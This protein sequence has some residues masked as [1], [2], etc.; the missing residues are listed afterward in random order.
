M[1]TH[2][3]P[4]GDVHLRDEGVEREEGLVALDPVAATRQ[5]LRKS[6]ARSWLTRKRWSGVTVT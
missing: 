2:V 6:S 3:E 5:R 4:A 1:S